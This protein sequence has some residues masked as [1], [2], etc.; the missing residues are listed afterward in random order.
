MKQNL[1]YNEPMICVNTCFRTI[2]VE[3]YFPFDYKEEEIAAVSMLLPL[4]STSKKYPSEDMFRLE[5]LKRSILDMGRNIVQIGKQCFLNFY[6]VVVEDQYLGKDVFL[7]AL[8]FLLDT[9]YHPNVENGAFSEFYFDCEKKRILSAIANN[10]KKMQFSCNRKVY[11]LIDPIGDFK[12]CIDNHVEQLENLSATDLYQFYEKV[13]GSCV[14]LSF[15]FGNVDE[16]QMKSLFQVHVYQGREANRVTGSYNQFLPRIDTNTVFLEEHIPFEQSYLQFVYKV[17]DMSEDDFLLLRDVSALLSSQ[18][19]D[20]L[21]KSLRGEG[22]LVYSAYS[23]MY[24]RWGLLIVRA[25]IHRDGKEEA[26]RRIY[27]VMDGLR[28]EKKIQPLLDLI[29]DRLR[30]SLQTFTD[31]KSRVFGEFVDCRLGLAENHMDNYEKRIQVTASDIATFMDRLELDLV[32]YF[33]GD[34]DAN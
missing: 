21:M 25:L 10:A 15:V 32:Y 2:T 14:P 34:K 33:E 12:N 30:I 31:S 1:S 4:L 29:H 5:L 18:S 20:L 8:L 23:D 9:I 3:L 19:S 6:L 24:S 27:E 17:K 7:E 16:K 22:G 11:D 28:D 13:I 26:K